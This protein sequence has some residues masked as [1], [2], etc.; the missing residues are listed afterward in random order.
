MNVAALVGKGYL[1]L[2]ARLNVLYDG[3][4]VLVYTGKLLHICKDS[5]SKQTQ[6]FVI[7]LINHAVVIEYDNA[8]ID[9]IHNQFVVFF[10]LGGIRFG[11]EKNLCDAVK[12]FTD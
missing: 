5:Q 4:Q 2:V 12:R 7:R 10:F 11:L 3:F 6:S 8:G 1:V 9:A